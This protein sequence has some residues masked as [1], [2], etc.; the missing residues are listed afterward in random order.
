MRVNFQMFSIPSMV[1]QMVIT[2]GIIRGG[3]PL[4]EMRPKTPHVGGWRPR[5]ARAALT[6][7]YHSLSTIASYQLGP[8]LVAEPKKCQ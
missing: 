6:I 8:K 3:R 1:P 4:T 5:P 2:F 7:V